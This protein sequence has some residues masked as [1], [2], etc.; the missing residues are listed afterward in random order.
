MTEHVTVLDSDEGVMVGDLDRVQM[1]AHRVLAA[2]PKLRDEALLDVRA[3]Y[4]EI[5]GH[6]WVIVAACDAEILNRAAQR[7]GRGHLDTDAVGRM[8]G[9]EARAR[10]AGTSPHEVRRNARLFAVFGGTVIRADH[11]LLDKQFYKEALSAADPHAAIDYAHRKIDENL[12]YSSREFA[13]DMRELKRDAAMA[14]ITENNPDPAVAPGLFSVIYADPPWQ[15]EAQTTDPTRVIE[16]QYPTMS[17]EQICAL[18]LADWC[19]DAAVLFLWAPNPKLEEALTVMRAWGFSYRT[20]AVWVKDKI[21]LGYW[22]RQQHELLLVGRRGAMPAPL[23]H[24]RVASVIHAPR[25]GHSVKPPE[26]Y[27]IIEGMYPGVAY[28][29]LFARGLARPGWTAWGNQCRL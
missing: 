27:D 7:G 19:L 12:A 4:E 1:V 18:P 13:R 14:G 10:A 3:Y 11:S 5:G 23:D 8:A 9:Y 25:Q 15:Y 22:F 6:A 28:L 26:V 29:E 16:N 17:Q 21:G 2:I 20:N 24:N